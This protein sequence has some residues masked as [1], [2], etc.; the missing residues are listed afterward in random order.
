MWNGTERIHGGV[1][2]TDRGGGTIWV[3]GGKII[4]MA[5]DMPE[6]ID[7]RHR[8]ENATFIATCSEGAVIEGSNSILLRNCDMS[9]F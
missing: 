7:R 8:A 1:I 2:A 4:S 5:K 6:F 3:S 9:G